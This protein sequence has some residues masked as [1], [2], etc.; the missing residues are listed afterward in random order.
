MFAQ[1]ETTFSRLS[2]NSVVV[3]GL[4]FQPMGCAQ[5]DV[6][7]FGITFSNETACLPSAYSCSLWADIQMWWHWA[8]FELE[9]EEIFQRL[10][11]LQGIWAP[12][13]WR[14]ARHL[15]L[16]ILLWVD[17]QPTVFTP[18]SFTCCILGFLCYSSL[19]YNPL[20]AV[21][22]QR[23]GKV[24]WEQILH[25]CGVSQIHLKKWFLAES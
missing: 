14:S 2:C 17:H 16:T 1:P 5:N 19:A 10:V 12:G 11:E 22:Q 9:Y 3:M 4:K 8:N 15:S 18:V 25:P 23:K 21:I 20:N 7:N 24:V 13:W 6:Y